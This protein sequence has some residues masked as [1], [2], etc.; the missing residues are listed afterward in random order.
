MTHLCQKTN[1]GVLK[2]DYHNRDWVR[3]LGEFMIWGGLV[4]LSNGLECQLF[5]LECWVVSPIQNCCFNRFYL[6]FCDFDMH[7]IIDFA[8]GNSQPH[9]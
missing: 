2:V 3:R 4:T 6:P 7:I 9:L 5:P 1:L 8:Y